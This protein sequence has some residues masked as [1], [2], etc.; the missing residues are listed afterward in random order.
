MAEKPASKKGSFLREFFEF[1]RTFGVIGLAIAFVI[2]AASSGLVT[3][4]V[5]DLINPLIGLLLPAGDLK[6]MSLS[7]TNV[8]GTSSVFKYGDFVSSVINFLIIALVVFLAY[9]Q[10]SKMRLVEDKTKS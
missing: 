2:G 4:L 8:S 3:A 1:M 6:G 7:V 10:L 5:N 9:R